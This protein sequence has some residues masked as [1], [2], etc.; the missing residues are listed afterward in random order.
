[1]KKLVKPTICAALSFILMFTSV[2]WS[3]ILAGP[4]RVNAEA[5]KDVKEVIDSESTKNSTTFRL[6]NGKKESVFYGQDVRYEDENGN[7]KDYDPTLVEIK[8]KTSG[9]GHNLKDY[10][11]ENKDGDKKQYL[12]KKLTE[13]TPVLMEHDKYEISFAPI[14]GEEESGIKTQDQQKEKTEENAF[15]CI[16]KLK[17][18]K[19]QREEVLTAEDKK[20]ELP[21]SVAYES[22][23]KN[24]T[25]LYQSLDTGVKE[26]VTLKEIPDSNQLKFRFYAKNLTAKKNIGD[27]GITFYDKESE[28]IIASLE[29]P[30]MNDDTKEAYNEKLSYDIKPIK[31]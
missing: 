19:L 5:S 23:D 26:S 9:H 28:D 17:R 2:Q 15:S 21:V 31:D 8:D 16:N 20:E 29:A 3:G 14:T 12:P 18:T 24:C 4:R 7:L 6:S 1:M 30:S 27:G 11:Y 22:E 13:S 10:Q 25:F